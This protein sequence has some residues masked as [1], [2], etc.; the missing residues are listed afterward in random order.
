MRW[1]L[2]SCLQAGKAKENA[3]AYN[4][5]LISIGI[6]RQV[7]SPQTHTTG[8]K[9]FYLPFHGWHAEDRQEAPS[10]PQI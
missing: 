8:W 2:Q 3:I 6:M 7:V 10:P 1:S 9:P 4:A 5:E